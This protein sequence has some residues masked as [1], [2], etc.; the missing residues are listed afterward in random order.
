MSVSESTL[1][2]VYAF[3]TR[4]G[5]EPTAS[6]IDT[7]Q[8]TSESE[9]D[10]LFKGGWAE[11]ATSPCVREGEYVVLPRDPDVPLGEGSRGILLENDGFY[12]ETGDSSDRPNRCVLF[13][14]DDSFDMNMF[15]VRAVVSGSTSR[16]VTRQAVNTERGWYEER[17]ECGDRG[18]DVEREGVARTVVSQAHPMV[19]IHT[20]DV[21]AE[22]VAEAEDHPLEFHHVFHAR[23][24]SVPRV[25][26]NYLGDDLVECVVRY[27][28]ERVSVMV[29]YDL[30]AGLRH[31]D[32]RVMRDGEV[33]FVMVASRPRE[34]T[35][36]G[37]FSFH[38]IGEGWDRQYDLLRTVRREL[39][40]QTLPHSRVE[41]LVDAHEF[42]WR[43]RL[44]VPSA[45]R[46]TP[47]AS[48]DAK[49]AE[50]MRFVETSLQVSLFQCVN[51]YH[52]IDEDDLY[53]TPIL[54]ALRP[55]RARQLL[56]RRIDRVNKAW[57]R[58]HGYEG[59][60]TRGEH[61][62]I[63]QS[64]L[65]VF[66]MWLY[67]RATSDYGWLFQRVGTMHDLTRYINEHRDTGEGFKNVDGLDGARRD[68]DIF[69]DRVGALALQSTTNAA[70]RLTFDHYEIWEDFYSIPNHMVVTADRRDVDV[71]YDTL[72]VDTEM[73]DGSLVYMWSSRDEYG[74]SVPLGYAFGEDACTQMVLAPDT[75]YRVIRTQSVRQVYPIDILD[76]MGYTVYGLHDEDDVW[77]VASDRL[78]GYRFRSTNNLYQD[79][80]NSFSSV[81][82]G[83]KA[84]REST[85]PPVPDTRTQLKLG[86]S[87]EAL[88]T[89]FGIYAWR[90]G[91]SATVLRNM[92]DIEAVHQTTAA[93]G[94]RLIVGGLR[95]SEARAY[96]LSAYR[97]RKHAID[98]AGA[99]L[100]SSH[101]STQ[102]W[103]VDRPEETLFHFLFGI[104]G[105]YFSGEMTK[106]GVVYERFG[107]EV[108]NPSILPSYMMAVRV[109]LPNVDK[110]VY[111]NLLDS[112]PVSAIPD[113]ATVLVRYLPETRTYEVRPTLERLGLSDDIE[114]F[115]RVDGGEFAP[116]VVLAPD[117]AARFVTVQTE[118]RDD[119]QVVVKTQ[120]GTSVALYDH[121]YALTDRTMNVYAS[122]V[123]GV[124]AH[125]HN[126]V[127]LPIDILTV[128]QRDAIGVRD[129]EV[130][131]AFHDPTI[132][133]VTSEWI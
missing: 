92:A 23:N 66:H 34:A 99:L 100:L 46:V 110:T 94:S 80:V 91:E 18:P 11:N 54:I 67:H 122:T 119:A 2:V 73:V 24:A 98:A 35:R 120:G 117:D 6:E 26:A 60:S 1:D 121:D 124:D 83:P 52:Y 75:T 111:N 27:P 7:L 55:V 31:E 70:W 86:A 114:T 72:V 126:F 123:F 44:R 96:P 30:S 107:T 85:L 133:S 19:A 20:V 21:Q 101:E 62:R 45:L 118:L 16:R 28:K 87:A 29:V 109:D 90:S 127:E 116:E 17:F 115:V 3:L 79:V 113:D 129:L 36:F 53:I 10:R 14:K 77:E 5:R 128:D 71:P 95:G 65:L 13:D 97:E 49:D 64:A 89:L 106:D 47:K 81:F 8:Y 102:P 38:T 9:R 15:D 108:R 32:T 104:V 33:R 59:A 12:V 58:R 39:F 93:R 68:D 57:P 82:L 103:G 69:T 25:V 105:V 61:K 132:L 4:M 131:V 48:N 51:R 84:F 63:Y 37:F 76:T 125:G 78:G 50:R 88:L 40:A 22:S 41:S 43:D 112:S 56:E 74:D 42:E 130:R